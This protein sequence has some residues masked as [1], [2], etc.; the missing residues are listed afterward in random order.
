MPFVRISLPKS[1]SQETKD[2]ISESVHRSLIQEFNIPQDDYFHIIE[3]LEPHQIKFPTTYLG[4]PHT[5]HIVYIQIIA[6]KGRTSAQKKALYKEIA[7][8][9]THSTIVTKN[10]IIIVLLE[11]DGGQDWS[12]GNGETQELK[13][14]NQ[15]NLNT[16][17]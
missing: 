10:N 13:H 3:E 12:F 15:Q 17:K 4:I 14:L 6:G 2:N 11:N 7:C 8:R 1:F 16:N 5:S 9:I